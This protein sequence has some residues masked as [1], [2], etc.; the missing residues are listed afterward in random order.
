MEN[1]FRP[2]LEPDSNLRI[3][4]KFGFNIT[5]FKKFGREE[6]QLLKDLIVYMSSSFQKNLFG[7]ISFDLDLFCKTMKHTRSNLLRTHP[8][9]IF[10]KLNNEITQEEHLRLEKK[11]GNNSKFR[12][13]NNKIEN[14]FLILQSEMFYKSNE[15]YNEN[16]TQIS[17]SNFT[18]LKETF[19][20]F[21]K[22]NK[23]YKISYQ[24]L[25]SEEFEKTL[26]NYFLVS[27]LEIYLK[28]KKGKLIDLYFNLL[29]R[30]QHDSLKRTNS[31]SFNLKELAELMNISTAQ[32]ENEKGFSIIKN[33][34]KLKFKKQFSPYLEK[35]ILGLNL[36]FYKGTNAK[37]KNV[38]V[39]SWYLKS[40]QE[41]KEI[42]EKTYND[43]FFT[44]LIKALSI[45]YKENYQEFDLNEK[46]VI[47]GFLKWILSYTDYEIKVS[48]YVSVFADTQGNKIDVRKR[49]KEFFIN[50]TNIGMHHAEEHFIFLKEDVYY[51][52]IP[53]YQK[54]VPFI[55]GKHTDI[56]ELI[57]T[58]EHNY[59]YIQ[60]H[61]GE[62]SNRKR[63]EKLKLP[64][65]E[66]KIPPLF[67]SNK[68]KRA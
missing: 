13:W 18:Y 53:T 1:K 62:M 7:I 65:K 8:D 40:E 45:N 42:R 37:Y 58:L 19:I 17:H 46:S 60:Y 12:V 25:P 15:V 11:Y 29:Y 55:Q 4:R 52:K 22:V 63:K 34:I 28:I 51:Y 54:T 67:R 49:A 10:Y 26:K 59:K 21:Q 3:D 30:S 57:V 66:F 44:E 56:R 36:E 27:N 50:L 20:L 43:L 33:K 35:E 31:V 14:A 16:I 23:T 9:P 24:Y 68:N 64:Q 47:K 5:N 61:Y 48:K 41:L 32:L 6:E 38:P 2:L 39:I